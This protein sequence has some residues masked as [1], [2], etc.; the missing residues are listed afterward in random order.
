MGLKAT[1]AFADHDLTILSAIL[2][3]AALFTILGNLVADLLYA[4]VDPRVKFAKEG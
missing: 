1:K 2:M 3:A 4:W